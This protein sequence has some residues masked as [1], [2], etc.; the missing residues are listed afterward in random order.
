MTVTTQ[1]NTT[2]SFSAGALRPNVLLNPNLPSDQRTVTQWFDT[3]AYV[4]PPL[5]QFG[6]GGVGTLRAAGL[7]NLD[8]SVQR[9]FKFTERMRLQ[10]RGEFIDGINHT[11]FGLPSHTSSG[12]GFGV[13]NSVSVASGARSIQIGARVAF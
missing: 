1:T 10:L 5:F 12:S 13:I 4:Q 7:V 8:F 3:G 9:E 11:N 2:N 6:N